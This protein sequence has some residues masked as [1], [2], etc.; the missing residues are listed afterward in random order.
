MKR[1]I[2][3]IFILSS[4]RLFSFVFADKYDMDLIPGFYFN[5]SQNMSR[6]AQTFEPGFV[7]SKIEPIDEYS[8]NFGRIE[9]A[10]RRGFEEK[11]NFRFTLAEIDVD[12]DLIQLDEESQED[13]NNS[14]LF[15]FNID[16]LDIDYTKYMD[17]EYR[18]INMDL[19][20]GYVN[21]SGLSRLEIPLIFNLS[22]TLLQP[23]IEYY[24]R[25]N[26]DAEEIITGLELG[27]GTNLM[28][29]QPDFQVNWETKLRTIIGNHNIWIAH[30]EFLFE[31]KLI[32]QENYEKHRF[33]TTTPLSIV[34]KL[35]AEYIFFKSKEDA[36]SWASIG[37]KVYLF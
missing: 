17:F 16:I 1:L 32:P 23:G 25:I 6:N 20:F 12:M 29:S 15:I 31:Y 18:W 5:Y 21:N 26:E 33:Q 19:G 13:F 10:F 28:Y 4:T 36:N 9:S 22:A 8:I 34:A 30:S 11:V 2:I 27:L 37:F 24:P 14:S 7:L 3:I 35:G